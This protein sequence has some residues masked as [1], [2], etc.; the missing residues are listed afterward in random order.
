MIGAVVLATEQGLGVLAKQFYDNGIIDIV[1]IHKH[2]SRN[3]HY[4]WYDNQTTAEGLLDVCDTIIFFETPFYWKLIPMARERGIKTI[5]IPMYECTTYPF[6]YEPDEIWTT[7]DLDTQFYGDKVTRQIQIPIDVQHATRHVA[8]TFVHN[9]GNGG[10]GGRN[11]TAELI[12][13]MK[14]V[15]S[16]IKL[17]INSQ[18]PI[19]DIEDERITVFVGNKPYEELWKE[20][21]VFVFPEKFNGLSLPL[22]E[23]FASGMLVIATDRFP[24]NTYLPTDPLIPVERYKRERIAVEFDSAVIDPKKIAKKID[25]WYGKDITE[26]SLLGKAYNEVNSWKNQKQIL[27]SALGK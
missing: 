23:A 12:E 25:E 1:A 13:A 3:N 10:L 22:Q 14:Y 7:S 2:T 18:V 17:V 6:P 8:S 4:D 20:G 21:D 19:S 5:L 26:Y 27:L 24:N 11:G 16:P 15:T 9:A